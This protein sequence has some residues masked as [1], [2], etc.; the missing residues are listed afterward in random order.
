MS[1]KQ[2]S[3]TG[4]IYT[5]INNDSGS[6]KT[7]FRVG[8]GDEIRILSE[9]RKRFVTYVMGNEPNVHACFKGQGAVPVGMVE[10]MW[11]PKT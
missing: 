8:V 1:T 10:F 3:L 2:D 6:L 9:A 5:T 11:A 4:A 7:G